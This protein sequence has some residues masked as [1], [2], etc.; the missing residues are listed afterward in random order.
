MKWDGRPISK[1]GIYDRV[2]MEAYHGRLTVGPSISSSGLRTIF[3]KS[4]AH[5]F[6]DSYLNSD[7]EEQTEKE[8][9]VLG[10]AAHH[11]LLG[12]DAFSTLFIVRPDK[13]DSWRTNDAKAWKAGQEAQGRTVLL[14]KQIECIR[15]MA[16][17]LAAH[18]LVESGI[19]NGDVE[20]SLVW[21][22]KE[23]GIWLKSRPDAIPNDSGDFADLKST[24]SCGFEID[25]DVSNYRYDM[26]AAL[27]KWGAKAVLDQD[28]ASFSF[29]F[30]GS[31]KPHC[32]DVLTLDKEDIQ[33][34]EKDLRVALRVFAR[35]IET[36][37]WFGPSGTQSDARFVHLSDWAKQSA[38]LRREFLERELMSPAN[39]NTPSAEQ[40]LAAG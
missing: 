36:G 25:R 14:T 5:Y 38:S 2:P 10:R 18:P 37:N 26:Q 20:Q 15:G 8:H 24:A 29:V 9:F 4:P 12:E 17:S 1:D 7:R 6:V 31:T 21:K 33:A 19:L 22:D 40:C 3:A 27:T 39:T 32:V 35:C 23:T 30:V 34:A 13:W 16:R 11:L 28:M